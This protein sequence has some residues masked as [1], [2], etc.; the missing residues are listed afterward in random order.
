MTQAEL[1]LKNVRATHRFMWDNLK[2]AS[3]PE[4]RADAQVAVVVIT[5]LL[6]AAIDAYV[7]DEWHRK[8]MADADADVVDTVA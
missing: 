6:F 2:S 1:H 3:T 4:K 7:A 8:Q 5:D